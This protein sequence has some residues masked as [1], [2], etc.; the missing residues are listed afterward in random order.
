MS[1]FEKNTN[2]D[3][4][5]KVGMRI[6][7]GDTDA[8]NPEGLKEKNPVKP[9]MEGTIDKIDS[10][11][12]LHVLW[13]PNENGSQ[14][15][16]G[17]IPNI[18]DYTLLPSLENQ[19]SIDSF[20]E[21]EKINPSVGERINSDLGKTAN[22]IK[23]IKKLKAF[24]SEKDLEE[25]MSAGGGFGLAGASS[26]AFTGPL[27]SKVIKVKDLMKEETTTSSLTATVDFVVNNLLGWGTK[28]DMSPP[29]PSPAKKAENNKLEDWW[30][31]K[32]PTYN[33]GVIT[34][35]YAKTNDV[36]NDD[37]LDSNIN[38]DMTQFQKDVY[39]NPK[40]YKQSVI[41]ADKGFDLNIEPANQDWKFSLQKGVN[42]KNDN[43]NYEIQ[44]FR[45]RSYLRTVK[46]EGIT[47]F[48]DDLL[49]ESK[50]KNDSVHTKNRENE[51][52]YEEEVNETTTFGSVFGGGFPVTPTFAAKKGQHRPS[53]KP[54]WKGGQ[55]IQKIDSHGIFGE[56]E[57][58]GSLLDEINKVKWTK[59]AKYVKIKDKCAKYNNQPWCSQGA[60]DKPLELSNNTFESIKKVSKETGLP[61]NV[62]LENINKKLFEDF[63][64][65]YTIQ[66]LYDV[67]QGDEDFQMTENT[68]K[69]ISKLSE[70]LGVSE[71]TILDKIK[72]KF[73]SN[74]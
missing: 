64:R 24:E 23:P 53:K 6:R 41:T 67:N 29:W 12:T 11:G 25:T 22:K 44:T 42:L 66:S 34:D 58:K 59:G 27:E 9:D 45:N 55:I 15:Y 68:I 54:L 18:D 1:W 63:G 65:N 51:S 60:I 17:V 7:M 71:N 35:P 20:N 16:F 19:V 49:S 43:K 26:Y 40:K 28:E 2:F 69:N 14:R 3:P 72:S 32:I 48:V 70:K 62:I 61:F 46:K 13:D 52:D 36:W 8:F 33:G 5:A 31:Q 73:K 37:K 56:S 30:W 50:K 10:I 38:N 74:K 57:E 21:S 4:I 39:R 47:K